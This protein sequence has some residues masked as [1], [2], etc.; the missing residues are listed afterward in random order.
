MVERRKVL[1]EQ[2]FGCPGLFI[3][4]AI[5]HRLTTASLIKGV[6]DIYFQPFEKLESG[7]T[8]FRIEKVDIT[9]NH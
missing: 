8:D 3:T 7:D 1:D 2:F 6:D 9:G 5:R 4:S